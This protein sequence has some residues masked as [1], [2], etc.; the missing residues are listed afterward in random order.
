MAN[1][2]IDGIATRYEVLG[3]G[4]PLLMY[5]PGGF[6]ATI[7]KW[8]QQGVYAKVKPLDHLP[9][10]YTCIVFDR[11]EC[12][13]SGG[14]VE[15]VT[16]ADYVAQGGGLLDHLKIDKAHL[17]GGCMGCCPVAGVRRRA[18]RAGP[19]HDPLLACGRRQISPVELPALRRTSGLRTSERSRS[20]RRPRRQGRQ[21]VRDIRAAVPG[22]R[23]SSTMPISP[24]LTSNRMS[25]STSSS[26]PA[27]AAP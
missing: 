25:I 24:R 20:G 6:D 1:A 3:S 21:A 26:S 18:P 15:R 13:L 9:K 14:R 5:S 22:P 23:C 2:I 19:Q 16:W 7:E 11:R 17:M 27:W 12:G 10:H 4:P 8:S